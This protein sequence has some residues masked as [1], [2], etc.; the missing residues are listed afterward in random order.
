MSHDPFVALED[1]PT[2]DPMDPATVHHPYSAFIQGN[3]AGQLGWASLS[4]NPYPMDTV[5]RLFWEDGFEC[6]QEDDE[7]DDEEWLPTPA[8]ELN[9]NEED[10]DLPF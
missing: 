1:D 8:W 4:M 5:E 6:A 7:E 10:D 2:G 3:D 9:A